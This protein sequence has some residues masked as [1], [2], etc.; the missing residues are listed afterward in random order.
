MSPTRAADPTSSD[1]SHAAT[2]IVGTATA[3]TAAV[4]SG[5]ALAGRNALVTCHRGSYGLGSGEGIEEAL[6]GSDIA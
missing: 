5:V 2:M 6:D 4:Y 1:P 3:T